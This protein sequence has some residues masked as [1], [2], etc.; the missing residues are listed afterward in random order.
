[1]ACTG[2]TFTVEVSTYENRLLGFHPETYRPYYNRNN[3]TNFNSYNINSSTYNQNLLCTQS[4]DVRG[5]RMFGFPTNTYSQ[6]NIGSFDLYYATS[7]ATCRSA[8]YVRLIGGK[9]RT[10]GACEGFTPGNIR[11]WMNFAVNPA[12]IAPP[13]PT[14]TNLWLTRSY[15]RLDPRSSYPNHVY[16]FGSPTPS[17]YFQLFSFSV[18]NLGPNNERF[19]LPNSDLTTGSRIMPTII[20][21]YGEW[22]Q[23]LLSRGHAVGVP[24]MQRVH[25]GYGIMAD[26]PFV[27]DVIVNQPLT[28]EYSYS[29]GGGLNNPLNI[30]NIENYPLGQSIDLPIPAGKERKIE[31]SGSR[32]V[33]YGTGNQAIYSFSSMLNLKCNPCV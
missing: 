3:L 10:Y 23:F 11:L 21:S 16:D 22:G 27:L 13:D 18:T 2:G 15:A 28:H 17:S 6:L 1:M 26:W 7:L 30:P 19:I 31:I 8:E 24:F 14:A 9:Y 12:L 25:I 20:P 33:G 29:V 5:I 4:I 32:V